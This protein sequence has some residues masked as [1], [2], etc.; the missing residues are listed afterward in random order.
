[1]IY[2]PGTIFIMLLVGLLMTVTVIDYS[3]GVSYWPVPP[4]TQAKVRASMEGMI[5]KA[6][7]EYGY[8][9][10]RMPLL[11]F[12][13]LRP[14]GNAGLTDCNSYAIILDSE[15]AMTRPDNLINE[16]LPHEVAHIV[17][18]GVFDTIGQP[19]PHNDEWREF[20]LFLGGNDLCD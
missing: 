1:M 20:C 8:P 6:H 13:H 7:Q 12:D 15:L 14:T 10:D 9:I 3:P 18:C 4:A 11:Y 2:R 16:V 17:H 5:F 19:D